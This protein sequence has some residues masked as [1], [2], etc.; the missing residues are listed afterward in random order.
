MTVVEQITW[1]DVCALDDLAYDRGA[2]ALV[3]GHQVALF[4]VAPTG[5]LRAI[6]NHDPFSDAY[7]LSRGIVGSKGDVLK[8]ASPVYKQSFDL[9]TG[10]CLDDPAVAVATFPVRELDGRVL[11]GVP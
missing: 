4:R 11:V 9:R 5:E 6:A 10:Q 3:D 8:V 7:V 1:I 2:C